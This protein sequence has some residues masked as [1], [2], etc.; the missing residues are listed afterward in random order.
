MEDSL[1]FIVVERRQQAQH[2]CLGW[3]VAG[4]T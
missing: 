3:L 4:V 1:L 2:R